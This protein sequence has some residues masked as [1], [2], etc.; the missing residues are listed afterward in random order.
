MRRLNAGLALALAVAA[1]TAMGCGGKP[2]LVHVTGLVKLDGKPVEGVRV[3]FW[4]KDQTAKTFVNQF[5]IGFSDK[6]GRFFLQGTNGEGVEAG[7]YKVTFARPFTGAG[8]PPTKP[9]QKHEKEMLS[10]ELTELS[11]TK[12]TATVTAASNDFIFDLSS[13]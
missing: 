4:P 12:H 8:K 3:Y 10:P 2:K 5:A 7:E 11:K 9:N 1:I 6:D 13:Q